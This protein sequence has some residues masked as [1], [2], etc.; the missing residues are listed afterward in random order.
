MRTGRLVLVLAS[1]LVRAGG[2]DG[3]SGEFAQRAAAALA[4]SRAALAAGR[5]ADALAAA[6]LGLEHDPESRPLLEAAA[7]A[8]AAAG[9]RDDAL[10]W[11][12]QRREK[13]GELDPVALASRDLF[14]RHELAV[15]DAAALA[16]RLA[17]E[18]PPPA[19]DAAV[20]DWQGARA[21]ET[22]HYLVQGDLDAATLDDVAAA[23]ESVH[24]CYRAHFRGDDASA[25]R[26]V[27]IRAYRS[28][29]EFDE[30]EPGV[31]RE[32]HG[33]YSPER[34]VIALYDPRGGAAPGEG[35]PFT[36]FWSTLFHEAAHPFLR[37]AARPPLP[38]WVNEG[39]ACL[40]EGCRFVR[41]GA[42][43]PGR[44]PRARLR[45]LVGLFDAGR[46]DLAS[47][48]AQRDAAR[49]P[50]SRYAVAWGLV[51][52]CF[53]FE[54][55]AGERPYEKAYRDFL[56]A[57]KSA[58]DRTDARARFES[59]F[60]E[61]PKQPGVASL[62]DFER[63]WRSSVRELAE[64][65]FGGPEQ[66][67]A[68]LALARAQA[69]RRQPDRAAASLRN[70]LELRP[71]DATLLAELAESLLALDDR[72]AAVAT[73]RRALAATNELAA[74]LDDPARETAARAARERALAL[75]AKADA[76]LAD[77]AV[78]A[79]DAL[80]V[81]GLATAKAYAEAGLLRCAL[82]RVD[83]TAALLGDS[84]GFRELRAE[85]ASRGAEPGRWRRLRAGDDADATV[86]APPG[87][88]SYRIEARVDPGAGGDGPDAAPAFGGIVFGESE[89]EGP[90]AFAVSS[91]GRL[92][93]VACRAGWDGTE[94]FALAIGETPCRLA[95]EVVLARDGAPGHVVC[96]FGGRAV[97]VDAIDPADF[98]PHA[99]AIASG[100]GVR[101]TDLRWRR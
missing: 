96:S 72:G 3:A 47:V 60:V 51:D 46:A 27:T 11:T 6:E 25:A 4:E 52:F 45:E 81:T 10:Y 56:E 98:T 38:V 18:R 44:V 29:A 58:D 31:P 37:G 7:R 73:A 30:R 87:A 48:V 43:E 40:F 20:A 33:F 41:G 14:D 75:L 99:A 63:R 12:W 79:N 13:G 65:T 70:A 17:G 95:V 90:R 21:R 9:R 19:H 91:R 74:H 8:A 2:D 53:R 100:A 80:L 83:E 89:R 50:L 55:E 59:A 62:D 84:R 82:A 61:R 42:V 64:R 67:D 78:A 26:R 23:L 28:R 71:D 92:A 35:R 93:L 94:E 85:L 34:N 39:T 22:R 86:V 101:V 88:V 5:A 69:G 76:H 54:D 77:D 16:K 68:W 97:R 57:W 32:I 66:A 15:A 24:R 1:A 36:A 49:F